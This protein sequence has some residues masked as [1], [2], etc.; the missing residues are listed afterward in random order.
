MGH[1]AFPLLLLFVVTVTDLVDVDDSAVGSIDLY[2]FAGILRV[3][4]GKYEPS[5][6]LSAYETERAGGV[7]ASFSASGGVGG[8]G[9]EHWVCSCRSACAGPV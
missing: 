6:Y 5:V 2:P 9:L 7:C 4:T 1:V 8:A 3:N